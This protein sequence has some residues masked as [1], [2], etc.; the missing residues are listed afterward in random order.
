VKKM[1]KIRISQI[2]ELLNS[3][4]AYGDKIEFR[5]ELHEVAFDNVIEALSELK[6]NGCAYEY[7]TPEISYLVKIT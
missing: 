1:L 2:E 7:I 6:E 4:R 3:L 5:G